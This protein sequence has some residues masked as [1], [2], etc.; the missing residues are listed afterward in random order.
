[1]S[2]NYRAWLKQHLEEAKV[3]YVEVGRLDDQEAA[4]GGS[5]EH[6]EKA[7]QM[8]GY[9]AALEKCL[10]ELDLAEGATSKPGAKPAAKSKPKAK[11]G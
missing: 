11:R 3:H 9:I 2:S 4:V 10:R 8:F 1:M 6:Y 5:S 7:H